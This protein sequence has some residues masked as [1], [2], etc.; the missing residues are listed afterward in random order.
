MK[1]TRRTKMREILPLL[2]DERIA[3]LSDK[4]AAC[5]LA[6]PLLSMT[7][8]EFIE[9]LDERYAMS[10]FGSNERVCVAFGRYKQYI[11]EMQQVTAYLQ[12]YEVEQEADEKAAANGVDFPSMQE[13]I[14]LDCVRH[15]NLHST[16]EAERLPIADWL[17]CVK[18]EGAAAQYQRKLSK[19]RQN[20][21]KHGNK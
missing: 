1:I 8:G 15:Y 5:P 6:K 16:A 20:K 7:C 12:R 2:N 21:A 11:A 13:R 14:L 10:F 3:M 18:S 19:I 4:V 9:A 17:L